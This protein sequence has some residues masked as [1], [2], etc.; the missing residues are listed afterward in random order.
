M[1]PS[2]RLALRRTVTTDLTTDELRRVPA[3]FAPPTA[4]DCPTIHR[5]CPSNPVNQCTILQETR[6]CADTVT[7]PTDVC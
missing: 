2:K 5:E 3:A 7:C 4:I 1:K 6:G